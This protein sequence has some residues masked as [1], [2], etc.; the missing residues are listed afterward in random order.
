MK[1]L[2][3][4]MSRA[5][6]VPRQ[7]ADALF[8]PFVQTTQ[9]ALT[10]PVNDL[11][12]PQN[13]AVAPAPSFLPATPTTARAAAVPLTTPS[14]TTPPP[15]DTPRT[16]DRIAPGTIAPDHAQRTAKR[17]TP[18]APPPAAVQPQA[19]QDA[20]QRADAFMRSL[21]TP[22]TEAPPQSARPVAPH[23]AAPRP[24]AAVVRD[25]RVADSPAVPAAIAL[26]P[27][28]PR[29]DPAPRETTPSPRR[30][31]R[32]EAGKTAALANRAA[33]KNATPSAPVAAVSRPIASLP[34]GR[35]DGLAH[36]VGILRFGLNQS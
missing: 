1:Y 31:A 15:P 4:L 26:T 33:G 3:R 10:D 27:P 9:W 18:A 8:D 20:I 34:V 23:V 28:P 30:Q 25:D 16:I 11:A 2:E 24:S 36:S 17:D 29:I 13:P 7:S 6:A 21:A 22:A 35:R 12:Q 19:P 32:R 5:L 14:R